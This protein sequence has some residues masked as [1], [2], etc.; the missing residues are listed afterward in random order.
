MRVR[1]VPSRRLALLFVGTLGVALAVALASE[2]ARVPLRTPLVPRASRGE[3]V[4]IPLEGRESRRGSRVFRVGLSLLDPLELARHEEL[5]LFLSSDTPLRTLLG[6][7]I[8]SRGSRCVLVASGR[9][10]LG[11][12]QPTVFTRSAACPDADALTAGEALDLTVEV[13]GEG[14]VSLLGFEPRGPGAEPGKIQVPPFRP[15]QE[16]LDARGHFVRYPETAPRVVLLNH[17]WRLSPGLGWLAGLA[18]AGFGLA[19]AGCLVFPTRPLIDASVSGMLRAGVG[20]A[21]LAG[22]LALLHAVL[23]PPLSGPDEPY[24]MLGFAELTKN[25]ALAAD[26]VTWMG[27]T[28]LWRTRQQPAERFRTIDLGAP[29][30]VEDGQLRATE[31]AMRSAALARLWSFVGPWLGGEPAPR[32]LL[33]LRLLNALVFALA[34]GVAVAFAVATVSEPFPQWLGFGFLFVPALPFFAMH[35]SETALLCSVYVLFATSLAVM[36]LDGPRAH[37]AGLLLGVAIGLMLAAGR[38]PWPLAGLVAFALLG[39]VLLGPGRRSGSPRAAA[40]VFWLGL[41]PGAALFFVLQDEAYRVMTDYWSR[42]FARLIPSPL[43]TTGAWLRGQ[44]AAVALLL[45]TGATLELALA[46]PRR[47]VADRLLTRVQPLVRG[48]ALALAWLVPLSLLGSLLL[49]YPQLPIAPLVPLGVL[50]RI[51]LVLGSMATMFRLAQPDFLL[52]SSFWVGFGWLDTMPG[53]AFQALLLLL[54]ALALVALLHDAARRPDARRFAWLLILGAGAVAALVLYSLATQIV[55][56]ALGGRYVVGWYLAVLTIVASVLTL[57]WSPDAAGGS[58]R[59]AR[60][61]GR[62]ATLLLVAGSVH[63]YCLCFILGRYF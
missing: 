60:G 31:V 27:E 53:P 47:L 16:A 48:A 13:E 36:F 43:R 26:T 51:A 34:V 10:E 57:D 22:S 20:A 1:L 9:P 49:P 46:R 63:V 2:S 32:V 18:C 21:L 8:R 33:A 7:E 12:D 30:V 62:A 29:H 54:V 25:P 23:E 41:A 19:A 45:A 14:G 24:H 15:G 59:L 55:P 17:M 38:S 37:W 4:E 58:V 3:P 56:I 6:A 40:L 61:S 28:H 50:E 42:D 35:V 39:R 11:Q 44:P 52:A 5:W